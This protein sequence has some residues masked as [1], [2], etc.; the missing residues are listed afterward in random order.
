METPP[1]R[2]KRHKPADIEDRKPFERIPLW[3]RALSALPLPLWYAFATL[4]AW[5]AEHVFRYRRA[6]IDGQLKRC[7][8]ERDAA[9]IGRTRRDFYRSFGQV[10]VEIIKAATITPAEIQRRVT[11]IDAEPARR[12]LDAGRSIIVVTSHNCNWE[13]ALLKLSIGMGHPVDAAFKP[14]HDRFGDRLMLTIRSR[15][16]ARMITAKR[17]LMRVLRHRGPARIVAM[18]ADQDPAAS[19]PR[20]V[21]KFMGVDTAFFVGP[22]VIARA[23]NLPAWYLA[24]HRESR[25]HYR[26]TFQPLAAAGETLP[27]G[28][29]IERYARRVEALTRSYPPEWLWNYRR[30]RVRAPKQTAATTAAADSDQRPSG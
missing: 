29:L 11:L 14:L 2:R 27:E 24:M 22:E 10:V 30:W 18:V 17:L 25:G 7:F 28:T 6:V 20:Y 23:G 16:G 3:V 12:T 5:L 9:W 26:V 19:G 8:P 21:T 15:F 13:W 1:K 4:F